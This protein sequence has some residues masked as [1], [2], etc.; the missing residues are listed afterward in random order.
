VCVCARARERFLPSFSHCVSLPL[1]LSLSLSLS[2]ARAHTHTYLLI[3]SLSLARARTHT[4]THTLS[5][6]L[7]HSHKHIHYPPAHLAHGRSSNA[8]LSGEINLC[9]AKILFTTILFTTL[10]TTMGV[11]LTWHYLGRST[12]ARQKFSLLLYSLLPSLLL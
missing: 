4:H 2:R 10:F 12:F 1:S 7:S 6:H 11:A 3:L 5:V 9:Q 8:A